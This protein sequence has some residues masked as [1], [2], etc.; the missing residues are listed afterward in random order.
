MPAPP[1]LRD[2][3]HALRAEWGP[4][5][6]GLTF[7]EG[8]PPLERLDVMLYRAG[9]PADVTAFATI[10]MAAHPMPSRDGAPGG[11]AELRL[12]RRGPLGPGDEHALAVRLANL[13]AYP[14]TRGEPL[15]WGEMVGF[16]DDLPAFPGCR[17]VFLAGPW[18]REQ[19]ATVPTGVE[20]VRVLTAVPISEAER[21][22]ALA[23]RPEDFF[24]SLLDTRD[25]CAPPPR[26]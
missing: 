16:D 13:A 10:G 11:R 23:A 12:L 15:G 26:H 7:D 2:V 22:A 21:E 9:G 5:D 18:T 19:P 14:W 17:R 3:F 8:P 20:P 1:I 24:A 25:V 6:D 4:E